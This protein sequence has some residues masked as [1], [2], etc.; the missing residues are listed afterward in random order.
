MGA[1]NVAARLRADTSTSPA[2]PAFQASGL[3]AGVVLWV[4]LLVKPGW[5]LPLVWNVLIPL[6]PALLVIAPGG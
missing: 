5:G 2:W 4:L 6:T 3:L 1:F